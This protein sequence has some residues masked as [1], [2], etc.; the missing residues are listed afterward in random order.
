MRPSSCPSLWWSSFSAA[1]AAALPAGSLAAGASALDARVSLLTVGQAKGLEFDE[2]V[3]VEPS[4][5][6]VDAPR[7]I[8]DLYVALTRATSRLTV[9]HARDLP[10]GFPAR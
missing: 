6:L 9:I 4:Q 8:H 7:G 3:V 2:V 5:F 10:P 1:L